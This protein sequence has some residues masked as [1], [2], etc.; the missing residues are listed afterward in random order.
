[1]QFS[2]TKIELLP[3]VVLITVKAVHLLMKTEIFPNEITYLNAVL[4]AVSAVFYTPYKILL[5]SKKTDIQS[6]QL[7]IWLK[8]MFSLFALGFISAAA[9][10]LSSALPASFLE[11]VSLDTF[12]VVIAFGIGIVASSLWFLPDFKNNSKIFGNLFIFQFL[13]II[14]YLP[15]IWP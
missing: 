7:K 4:L 14:I 15:K 13:L 5:L 2:K 8:I 9:V 12:I 1:M 11:N 3:V 10:E 6:F